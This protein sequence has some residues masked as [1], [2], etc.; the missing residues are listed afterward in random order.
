MFINKL[1]VFEKKNIQF[2]SIYIAIYL[3]LEIYRGD[4]PYG[5]EISVTYKNIL[6]K[7]VYNM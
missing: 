2:D 7:R 3:Q 1:L 5:V 4:E 6:L